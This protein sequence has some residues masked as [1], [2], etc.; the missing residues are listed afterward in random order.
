MTEFIKR[1]EFAQRL[2]LKLPT[3]G[4]V[5]GPFHFA[6]EVTDGKQMWV[7]TFSSSGITHKLSGRYETLECAVLDTVMENPFTMADIAT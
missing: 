3:V 4:M 5:A 6:L 2:A 7:V 1:A